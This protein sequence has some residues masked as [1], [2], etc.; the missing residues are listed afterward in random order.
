MDNHYYWVYIILCANNTYY[1]GYTNDLEKRY[2]AHIDGSSKCKYTRSFK[3]ISI[4]QSWK[5]PGEKAVAMQVERLIKSL[6]RAEKEGIIANP[7]LLTGLL[8]QKNL[9]FSF[10][11]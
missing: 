11:Q 10:I 5:I 7:H 3:P 1:T 6:S 4:A 8:L 9:D 2:Q